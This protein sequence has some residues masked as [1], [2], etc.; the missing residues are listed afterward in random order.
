MLT[1]KRNNHKFLSD[2][3]DQFDLYRHEWATQ[4]DNYTSICQSIGSLI[5]V[6][7]VL[8]DYCKDMWL[9]IS[10]GNVV[11]Y[12]EDKVG[13]ST[14][15]HKINPIKFENAMANLDLFIANAQNFINGMS[16]SMLQ[17]D[18]T[19]STLLRNLGHTMGYFWLACIS[20]KEGTE[21]LRYNAYDSTNEIDNNYQVLS[22][23]IQ[24]KLKLEGYPSSTDIVRKSFQA[25]HN[26]DKEL[27]EIVVKDMVG[28][29]DLPKELVDEILSMD[30]VDYYEKC[31]V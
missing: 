25:Y 21:P 10:N 20:I 11:I 14:M 6:A 5:H 9:Y 19:S 4:T 12:D 28:C 23:Y 18:L 3:V 26:M 31:H 2:F 16:R 29:M 7:N 22:E 30:P 17:R 24:L 13:S 8:H 15:S 1:G 27:Y